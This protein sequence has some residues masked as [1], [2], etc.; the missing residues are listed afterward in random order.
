MHTNE[1]GGTVGGPIW[2]P[3]LFDG[4]LRHTFF[5]FNHDGIRS[6]SPGTTSVYMNLPTL[7]ERNGDFS[8]SFITGSNLPN[9]TG[10]NIIQV[11]DPTTVNSTTGLRTQFPNNMIPASRISPIAKALFALMPAPNNP[12]GE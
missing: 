4:R 1:F 10:Q 5:F 11:Y 2:I 3:K 12:N 6:K 8:Q 9:P 7:A